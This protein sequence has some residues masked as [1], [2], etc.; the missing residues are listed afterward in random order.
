MAGNANTFFCFDFS[1][2]EFEWELNTIGFFSRK[3]RS[4]RIKKHRQKI[5]FL[6]P[7]LLNEN[8]CIKTKQNRTKSKPLLFSSPFSTRFHSSNEILI[9]CLPKNRKKVDKKNCK[10]KMIVKLHIYCGK[11]FTNCI[12]R[13]RQFFSLLLPF[14]VRRMHTK[15]LLSSI[16]SVCSTN[17]EMNLKKKK[18]FRKWKRLSLNL[19]CVSLKGEIHIDWVVI[20]TTQLAHCFDAFQFCQLFWLFYNFNISCLQEIPAEFGKQM[21]ST[22][23]INVNQTFW[24][25]KLFCVDVEVIFM[26]NATTKR[27][28]ISRELSV[29]LTPRVSTSGNL[30]RSHRGQPIQLN[31]VSAL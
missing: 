7:I 24:S 16:V 21:N 29:S 26:W 11:L 12:T 18:Q 20:W 9:C 5:Y 19:L 13:L 17:N 23:G 14:S 30:L 4:F 22:F 1:E 28:D 6:T 27:D 2:L 31:Q 10:R 25:Y 15:T 8:I 3:F